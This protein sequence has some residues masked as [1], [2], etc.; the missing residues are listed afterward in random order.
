[1]AGIEV[2]RGDGMGNTAAGEKI[3]VDPLVSKPDFREF[4]G[5]L[6][7]LIYNSMD[8]DTCDVQELAVKFGLLKEVVMTE[9]CGDHCVC[10]EASD[11]P[12]TCYRRAY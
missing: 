7:C 11:F 5:E 3:H 4:A 6:L 12:Q 1:M 9:P 8:I 10:A 2:A